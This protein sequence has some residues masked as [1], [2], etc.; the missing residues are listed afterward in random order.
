MC[1]FYYIIVLDN[2]LMTDR[3]FT[4]RGVKMPINTRHFAVVTGMSPKNIYAYGS[5][6]KAYLTRDQPIYDAKCI[7]SRRSTIFVL[8]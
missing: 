8:K 2:Y 5:I 3:I 7:F 6:E 1:R 4:S